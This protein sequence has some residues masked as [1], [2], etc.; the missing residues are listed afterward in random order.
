MKPAIA[1][2]ATL[3][4]ATS[5]AASISYTGNFVQDDSLEI[6]DFDLA[7]PGTVTLRTWSFAGGTNAAGAPIAAGGFAPV[8]SLF[9]ASGSEDLL[10]VD[11]AGGPGPCGARATDLSSG[12]CWDAW[13]NLNLAAG[14]YFLVLTEDD[15]TPSGLTFVDG[16]LQAGQ[17][18]F[19]ASEFGGPPGSQFILA[20]GSQRTS[21]WAVD[22]I[23]VTIPTIPSPEPSSGI[24]LLAGAAVLLVAIGLMNAPSASVLERLDRDA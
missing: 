14:S 18:N 10:G 16:F 2:A 23:G 6:F 19:T 11:H 17:G 20:G 1:I 3:L 12:F 7:S 22:L 8:L 5:Y 13:L 4:A 21:A 24:L 15:N 9:D